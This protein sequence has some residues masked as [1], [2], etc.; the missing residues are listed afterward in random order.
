MKVLW[1][2]WLLPPEIK[3]LF[4]KV[5]VLGYETFGSWFGHENQALKHRNYA[6][7]KVPQISCL[8]LLIQCYSERQLLMRWL[9]PQ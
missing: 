4:F 5:I 7:F 6:F 1:T 8:S 9:D 2:E 3:G